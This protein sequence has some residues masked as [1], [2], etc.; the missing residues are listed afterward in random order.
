MQLCHSSAGASGAPSPM[1]LPRL[2]TI[3]IEALFVLPFAD[4]LFRAQE[5][6]RAR[7]DPNAIQRSTQRSIK[8]GDCSE[9]LRR[10]FAFVSQES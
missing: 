6:H 1:S 2:D 3:G 9:D 7:F 5:V 8:T 10:E 4:L